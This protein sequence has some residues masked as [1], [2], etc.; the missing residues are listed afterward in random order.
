MSAEPKP[1]IATD[2]AGVPWAGRSFAH[3]EPS[4]DDGS[5]PPALMDAIGRFQ[6]GDTGEVEVVKALRQSRLFVPLVA[7]LGEAGE[8]HGHRSDKR[9]ELSIVTVA[10]PDGRNVLPA[11]SSV[12]SLQHWNPKAR[13]VAQRMELIALAAA[14]DGTDLVVL[15]A[16]S[17]TEFVVR[18]PALW[19]L[20]QSAPWIPSYSDPEVLAE[21]VTAAEAEPSV[22]AVRLAAGDPQ[23]RLAGPEL[24]VLLTMRDGLDQAALAEVLARMRVRWAASAVLAAR[25]DSLTVRLVPVG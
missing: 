18:R 5:A 11:F 4:T 15:D 20:A 13:P 22:V 16:T 2:S 6:S 3:V 14:D 24:V 19:A 12:Q 7:K 10:G 17:P 1:P 21:F 8:E 23:G 9:A 25:V